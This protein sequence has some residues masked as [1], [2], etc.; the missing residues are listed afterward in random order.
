MNATIKYI[1][2]VIGLCLLMSAGAYAQKKKALEVITSEVRN[3]Y[4]S[5]VEG[6]L[7]SSEEG[8]IETYT[9]AAGKF[10]I[11]ASPTGK[12]ML[13]ADGHYTK[14]LTVSEIKGAAGIE[15]ES[16][17][18]Q[19]GP[20][21][22]VNVPFSKQPKRLMVG[23]A[24][25]LDIN[26]IFEQDT[27][28]SVYGA[29]NGRVPG[30][31]QGLNVRGLGDALV[32]VDGIPRPAN[33]IN[34][35][36]VEKITVL[37]D[38]TARMLYGSQA[39]KGVIL[40]TTKRGKA[41]KKQIRVFAETGVMEA[42][43]LPKYLGTPEYMQLYNEALANDGRDPRF[44]DD[45]IRIA[46]KDSLPLI[47]PNENYYSDSYLKDY[48]SYSKILTEM[49]GGNDVAQYYLN[50]G[51]DQ[52]GS[53]LNAGAGESEKSNRFNI[54]GNTD[55]A[56]NDYI[57]AR[58]D[59]VAI[60]D[61]QKGPKGDYWKN[62]SEFLPFNYPALIPAS[63][64][65][66]EMRNSATLIDNQYVLGGTSQYTTNIYGDM[67]LAGTEELTQR[68][69]QLNTGLDFDL[70]GITKGLTFKSFLSFDF[71]N[72]SQNNQTNT[73]A[74]YET[75][76]LQSVNGADSLAFNRIGTDDQSG[77][78]NISD[79]YFYRRIGYYGM[80]DYQRTFNEKHMVSVTALAYADRFQTEGVIQDDK[81]LHFGLR[82]HYA[83]DN[84]YLVELD[85][86]QAGTLRLNEDNRWAFS[87][88]LGA[89]WILSEESFLQ[90]NKLINFLKLKASA[91][92][93]NS[94]Q[95]VSDYYLYTNTYQQ[96]G[97]YTYYDGLAQNDYMKINNVG[98]PNLSWVKRFELNAG[99]EL[100]AF[101]DQLY[102]EANY[103]RSKFYDSI[104]KR[105]NVYPA[106]L[107]GYLPYENYGEYLDQG[108]ELGINV[109]K[110]K[111]DLL[112]TFGANLLYAVPKVVEVDEP[113][114]ED[115]YR[116]KQGKST[117]ATFG[118]VAEGFFQ[119]QEEIESSPV[120]SFGAV[121]PGDIKYKD[122]N[123]DNIID[124]AD[125]Q[126]IGNSRARLSLG[127]NLSVKYKNLELFALG[128]AQKGKEVIYNSAY[129][130]VYGDRKY[131]EVVQG[132]WTPESASTATYPRLSAQNNANNFRNSTFWMVSDDHFNLG[133]VQ[134][135]YHLPSSWANK[136][137]M[138]N[139]NLFIKGN[140]LLTIGPSSER[141]Q[142]SVG[143]NPQ[144]RLY[145]VGFRTSF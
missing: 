4:G 47:Y 132:R 69:A 96:N 13:E 61:K 41:N 8:S 122:L 25:S 54:R 2:G 89:G 130:W 120:Q 108:L 57:T 17:P 82:A 65:P 95:G 38:V 53:F 84:K 46:S 56:I 100:A 55:V 45:Q 115:S 10:S 1:I 42:I 7:V 118:Y 83:F 87:P 18:Y 52:T 31:L 49:S 144:T 129:D 35:L 75:Q 14:V 6:V 81:N 101:K 43:S 11:K 103:F 131:S 139:A 116:L 78:L 77:K 64:L 21:D 111:G 136:A 23:S 80:L 94:D 141:R 138:K 137:A 39:D 99:F 28:Q 133:V 128:T 58:L 90:G 16:A 29:L 119:S 15:L 33:T 98:N 62:A 88:A 34:L 113:A 67:T 123:G 50:I 127:V 145:S 85:A 74:V 27:R 143:G 30:T 86:V 40:V 19:M 72:Y 5:P 102:M 48:N 60:L 76:V 117:D 114:F 106:Y 26:K 110:K 22:M 44:S 109:R 125:Q 20:D 112:M 9:D 142:L 68:T 12:V 70:S 134:L 104:V 36:E 93:I 63:L 124:E 92:L 51:W 105:N 140:N 126:L 37:R 32:V 66:E 91:G 135:T 107:G 59:V 24:T 3:Q 121:Q 71:H 79:A 73:Y 97:T